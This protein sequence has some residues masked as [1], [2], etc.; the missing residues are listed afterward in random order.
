MNFSNTQQYNICCV[1]IC[2][3]IRRAHSIYLQYVHILSTRT[4][5]KLYES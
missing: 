3:L 4:I 2:L 1:K 5:E